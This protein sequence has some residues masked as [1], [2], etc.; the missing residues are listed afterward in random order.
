MRQALI[1]DIH[2]NLEAL[3]AVM[4]DIREQGVDRVVCL[5]DIVGYG[6]NPCECLDIV[7]QHC[8]LTI[9]GNHDQAALFDPE[10][11]NPIA[12]RAIYWT[13]DALDHAHGPANAINRRWDFLSELP[14]QHR[15]QDILYVHGSPRDATNEY[16]FPE[17]V[18]DQARMRLLFERVPLYSF[19]GHTHMPGVFTTDGEFIT[20]S[21]CD[22]EFELGP[23][24]LM[25]NVGSVGQPRDED[26]RSCYLILDSS[27]Q[28]IQFRR[29][30]YDFESTIRKIYAITDLDD[31]LG[32]R[33]R[34]GR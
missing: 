11:F 32:D 24:K 15:E 9:L 17:S 30:N 26:N 27:A 23:E 1:S 33:L 4:S 28:L 14:K 13:R 12:L 20:P 5:G 25:I 19:Q 10:G 31:M 2:G 29:I 22:Y 6:P 8:Q 34:A 18:Y 21:D 16:V 7:M 3:Q